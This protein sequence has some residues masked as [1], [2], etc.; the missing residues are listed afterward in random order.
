MILS[1]WTKFTQKGYFQSKTVQVVQG[2]QAFA[3]CAVE[4]N[5]TVVSEHFEDLNKSHY[6][7]HFERKVGY[8]L[9]S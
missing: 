9:P 4:V 3:F 6:F 8:I 2:L 1:F 7:E 5:S